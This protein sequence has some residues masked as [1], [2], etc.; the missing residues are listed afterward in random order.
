MAKGGQDLKEETRRA[1][2]ENQNREI[3]QTLQHIKNKI[4]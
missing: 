4:L 1:Q 3:A 2:M